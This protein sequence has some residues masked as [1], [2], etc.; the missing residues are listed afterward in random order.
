[1]LSTNSKIPLADLSIPGEAPAFRPSELV[2]A[3]NQTLEYSYSS[4]L[5]VGEV[6]S[7]KINQDKWV[8]FDLKDE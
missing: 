5:L 6:S 2:A 4:V 3:I 1:M 7:F 8:F